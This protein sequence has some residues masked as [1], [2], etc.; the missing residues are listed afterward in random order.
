MIN[1]DMFKIPEDDLIAAV[2]ELIKAMDT[3][4]ITMAEFADVLVSMAQDNES[5]D[6]EQAE[7]EK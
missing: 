2:D 4:H 7:A 3:T 1:P 5:Q 6:N